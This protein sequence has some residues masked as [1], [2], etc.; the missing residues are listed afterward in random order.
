MK[1]HVAASQLQP[2]A[3]GTW[4]FPAVKWVLLGGHKALALLLKQLLPRF[5]NM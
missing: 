1:N 4:V 5:D 2:P 3:T